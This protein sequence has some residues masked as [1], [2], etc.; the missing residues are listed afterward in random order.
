MRKMQSSNEKSEEMCAKVVACLCIVLVVAQEQNDLKAGT[1]V[2]LH[3]L[4]TAL[5]NDLEGLVVK[6]EMKK[7]TCSVGR[8]EKNHQ[9]AVQEHH[10]HA[11]L[12]NFKVQVNET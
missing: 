10:Y 6:K 9:C 3:G 5:Y 8:N 12:Q 11:N 1:Y 7:G 2:R 4:N